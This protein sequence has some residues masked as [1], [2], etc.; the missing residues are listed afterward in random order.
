MA[1][2]KKS[3]GNYRGNPHPK[4]AHLEKH[5]WKKGQSGNPSGRVKVKPI[6]E[7]LREIIDSNPEFAH[8]ICESALKQAI[9]DIDWFT[10]V[11]D[12]LDGPL[13][14]G[15]PDGSRGKPINFDLNVRFVDKKG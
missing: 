9:H 15:S 14:S 8:K 7:T 5:K 2:K 11:R 6:L 12:M 1:A 10:E 4:T 13:E 3:K